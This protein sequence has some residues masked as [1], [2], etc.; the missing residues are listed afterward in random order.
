[1][2]GGW[3]TVRVGYV[4][5]CFAG[6]R[7]S[8][9]CAIAYRFAL[10]TVGSNLAVVV[11]EPSSSRTGWCHPQTVH[12]SNPCQSSSVLRGIF[13]LVLVLVGQYRY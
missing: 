11:G 13:A 5:V 2:V 7:S 9:T 12:S 8:W 6:W 4:V 1:M 10:P 3:S